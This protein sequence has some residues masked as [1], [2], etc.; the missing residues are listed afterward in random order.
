MEAEK[1]ADEPAAALVFLFISRVNNIHH[2]YL[3]SKDDA[4]ITFS[5]NDR[6]NFVS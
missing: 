4:K 5:S 2:L 1:E 6:I 3:S